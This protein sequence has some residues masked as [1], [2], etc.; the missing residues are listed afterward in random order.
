M[1]PCEMGLPHRA[2]FL[3]IDSVELHEPGRRAIA[4]KLFGEEEDFFKGHF[5]GD[6]IV[7]GVLLVEALA[8]TAGI[9]ANQKG[10]A[11]PFRLCAIRDMK[12]YL[13]V[14]PGERVTFESKVTGEGLGMTQFDGE[15]RTQAGVVASGRLV[16]SR[17][18]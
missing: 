8:Q 4:V 17:S 1:N 2:P 11:I 3:W 6:P 5:P 13:P 12:F 16:L 10:E 9:A 15:A 7:P 18:Q 14:R